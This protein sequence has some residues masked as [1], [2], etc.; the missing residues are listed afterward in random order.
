MERANIIKMGLALIAM[1]SIMLALAAPAL[2]DDYTKAGDRPSG[3]KGKGDRMGRMGHEP[4]DV[5]MTI[6]VDG[7][8]GN[9][10]TFAVMNMAMKG[11][12]DKAVLIMPGGPLT[13]TYNT[14]NDMGYISTA[15]FMPATMTVNTANNTSIPVAG[16]SAVVG[17][18]DMKVLTKEKGYKVF[19]FGEVSFFTPNGTATTYKLDKPVRVTYSEDR[20]MVVIDAYPS[21][22]R[23]MSEAFGTGATFPSGAQP[24]P[25][26]SLMTAKSAAM[27]ETV[28]YE[29]PAYVAPPK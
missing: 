8:T 20:K 2:A 23:Q 19:Q 24:V 5:Y 13:G 22:T 15:N 12:E 25:L 14:S 11:K 27:A 9:T 26:N 10:A 16:A 1:V 18:H 3:D 29:K 7:M 28:G 6:A 4:K 21:F 17:M